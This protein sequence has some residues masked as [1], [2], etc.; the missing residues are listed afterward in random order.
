MIGPSGPIQSPLETEATIPTILA[1]IVFHPMK[2]VFSPVK[3]DLPARGKTPFLL[4]SSDSFVSEFRQ[5]LLKKILL[6]LSNVQE[7]KETRYSR[8]FHGKEVS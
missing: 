6:I 3:G 8:P 1:S 7:G 5:S 4:V 2:S